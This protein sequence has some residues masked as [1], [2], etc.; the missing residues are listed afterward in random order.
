MGFEAWVGRTKSMPND[1]R[2]PSYRLLPTVRV[3]AFKKPIPAENKAS[4]SRK[5]IR[6]KIFMRNLLVQ[7]VAEMR[8]FAKSLRSRTLVRIVDIEANT[9]FFLASG[10]FLA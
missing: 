2:L 3:W 10:N 9:G 8:A 1:A 5:T 7:D 6:W 4:T